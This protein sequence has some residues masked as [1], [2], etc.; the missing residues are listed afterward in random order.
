MRRFSGT[1]RVQAP[2]VGLAQRLWIE[3]ERVTQMKVTALAEAAN[4]TL[5][6]DCPQVSAMLSALGTRFYF[7]AKGIMAQSGEAKVKATRYN[8]SIGI[9]TENGAPM[10]LQCV[11]KYF[12]GLKPN[13]V[14]EYAPSPGRPDLRQAW[15]GKIRAETP[16]LGGHAISLP[17]VTNALTHGLAIAGDLFLDKGDRV[18]TSDLY[19]ENYNLSWEVRLGAK[20]SYFPLFDKGLKGMDVAGFARSLAKASKNPRKKLMVVLNFPNNP[21]GYTPTRAEADG[22]VAALTAQAE[23]GTRLVVICDDAYYGM[24]FDD[25]CNTESLF[26][27]LAQ[28]HENLLAV[29]V[30]GATKEAFVWGFRVGFITYGVK[31]GTQAAYGVLEQKTAGVIR[32]TVSNCSHPGQSIAFKVLQDPAFRA[33]QAQKVALLRE[34]AQ[35]VRAAVYD[36]KYSD[37]WRVYPFNSGYFMCLKI[38]G[39]DAD[40][41]RVHLLEHH[42]LGTIALGKDQLRVAFSCLKAEE[43]PDVFERIAASVRALKA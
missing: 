18:L 32:A 38:K 10:H 11:A 20:I 43:I 41:V 34:R 5:S 15:L 21:S 9:A 40:P 30:C 8:A 23:A 6:K 19:W 33:E 2:G 4:A 28:A 24:F 7:P 14:Y 27:R 36:P 3:R 22:L 1:M 31:N 17:V 35:A 42:Q 13:E 16:S 39:V 25:A 26:G 37:C 12:Q 29:K